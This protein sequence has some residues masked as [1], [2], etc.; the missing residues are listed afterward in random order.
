MLHSI[1]CRIAVTCG[2]SHQLEWPEPPATEHITQDK[3]RLQAHLVFANI[4]LPSAQQYSN[5]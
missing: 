1:K 4:C 2:P 3:V 5:R